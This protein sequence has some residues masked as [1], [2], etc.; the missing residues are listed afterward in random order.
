MSTLTP[1]EVEQVLGEQLWRV[2]PHCASGQHVTSWKDN[3]CLR[4]ICEVKK[5]DVEVTDTEIVKRLL[6]KAQEP[7]PPTKHWVRKE[8]KLQKLHNCYILV[9][10]GGRYV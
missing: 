5:F 1:K 4:T 3:P 9:D 6:A 10:Q 7:K 2:C 8:P